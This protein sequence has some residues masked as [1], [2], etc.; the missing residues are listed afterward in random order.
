MTKVAVTQKPPVL[1]DLQASMACALDT[2]EETAAAGARLVMFPETF[3]PGYPHWCWHLTPGGKLDRA[4]GNEIHNR[5]RQNAVDLAT[6]DLAPLQEAAARLDLVV[7]MGFNEIDSAFSGSTLFNS[8]VIIG[9]D[10]Q[11]LN[12]HRKLMPTNPE[13]MVWGFGDASGLR[14]VDT[15]LGRIGSLICWENYMPLSRFALYAQGIDIYLAPTWDNGDTWIAS[16][17]HIAMEGGCW[18]LSSATAMKGSDVPADFPGRAQIFDDDKWFNPGDAVV[19][20]PGGGTLAGPMHKEQGILY[21]DID[22]GAA[23][24][25][26]K[27]LDVTGHYSRP[28]I[29]KLEVDR[30]PL[31][32]VSFVDEPL[33]KNTN[34]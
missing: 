10:G 3:L 2:L 13:R 25:S 30:S 34:R 1:L 9:A 18:V 22:I 32:A 33:T 6:D 7:G 29:F 23:R 16:M 21:A 14:V 12:C 11:L 4:L 8:Y 5:L 20:K 27:N 15:P 24:A 17:N 19:V 26:R 28:D 31:Q